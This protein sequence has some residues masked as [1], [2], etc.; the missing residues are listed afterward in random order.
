MWP[1]YPAN[2]VNQPPP[3]VPC[4]RWYLQQIQMLA[5]AQGRP[6]I[7]QA[8]GLCLQHQPHG[9][10][11]TTSDADKYTDVKNVHA[12]LQGPHPD[13]AAIISELDHGTAGPMS[14]PMRTA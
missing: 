10:Q 7:V 5:N 6:D 3:A 2:C 4:A 9:T 1:D 13:Y 8:A 12:A 14:A 11:P